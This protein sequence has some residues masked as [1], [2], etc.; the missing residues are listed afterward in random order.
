MF[1]IRGTLL[2]YMWHVEFEL[3]DFQIGPGSPTHSA[4]GTY[5]TMSE[6]ADW[7]VL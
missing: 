6:N 3:T 4:T 7:I 1:G 2:I 5:T